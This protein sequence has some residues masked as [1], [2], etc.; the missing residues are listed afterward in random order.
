M[1]KFRVRA[2]GRTE[3]AQCYL[4]HLTAEAAYIKLMSWINRYPNLM[5]RLLENGYRLHQRT[6]TPRQVALIVEA[7]GEP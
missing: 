5:T 4:P 7:L 1:E 6:F 3:L 2:Y